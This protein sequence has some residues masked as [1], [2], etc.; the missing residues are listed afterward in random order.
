MNRQLSRRP[1][2]IIGTTIITGITAITGIIAT[3]SANGDRG[4]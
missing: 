2:I 3:M 1:T 4:D